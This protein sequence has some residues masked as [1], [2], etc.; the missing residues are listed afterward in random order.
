MLFYT[1]FNKKIKNYS[2][3]IDFYENSKKQVNDVVRYSSLFDFLWEVMKQN[4]H[5]S[6][7]G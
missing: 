7:E 2:I 3:T 1:P 6:K 5:K 4:F